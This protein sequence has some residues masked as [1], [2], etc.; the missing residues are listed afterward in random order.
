MKNYYAIQ[1][2]EGN[3]EVYIFGDITAFPLMPGEVSARSLVDQLQALD[4]NTIDVHIDSC[5]GDIC[6]AWAIYNALKSHPARVR[7]YGDGFVAS[8]ALYP[9]LAGEERIA[10]N[11]SA[12]YLHQVVRGARGYPEELRA[13]ADDAEKMTE[14]GV[15]AFVDNTRMTAQE[16]L[17]LMKAETWLTPGE[18]LERGIATAI[19]ADPAPVYA[20][21]AK[22]LLLQKVLGQVPDHPEKT[23]P[24]ERPVPT[25]MQLLAGAFHLTEKEDN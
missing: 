19:Q 7:T 18:A 15:S 10:S 5:G 22:G 11:L 1:Q 17:D 8:A 21:S 16:V 4:A 23:K 3:A 2:A 9:F 13:A 14:I 24:Q 20:Q 12:Y 6:E 25:L